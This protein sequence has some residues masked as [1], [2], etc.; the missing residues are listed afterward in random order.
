MSVLSNA[1]DTS[2]SPDIPVGLWL[3]RST[4]YL[5]GTWN[6]GLRQRS[7]IAVCNV[8]ETYRSNSTEDLLQQLR[9]PSSNHAL[10]R[11]ISF[12]TAIGAGLGNPDR[13]PRRLG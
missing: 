4:V 12:A 3:R 7:F 1:K 11:S 5:N 6:C 9:K 8:V 2:Y 13:T 10:R